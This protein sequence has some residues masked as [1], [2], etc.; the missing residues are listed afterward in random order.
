M[1]R[2]TTRQLPDAAERFK[3]EENLDT[4]YLVEAAAGTGKTTSMVR[5]MTALVA[6]GKT[7]VHRIAAV[8]FTRK[9]ASEL[10]IR[11]LLRLEEALAEAVNT[12]D[13]EKADRIRE[14]VENAGRCFVGTIHSFCARL[15]RERPVEAGVDPAFTEMDEDDDERLRRVSWEEQMSGLGSEEELGRILAAGL[16]PGELFGLF[17]T[18]T[19]QPDVDA[20]PAPEPV[21]PDL[22]AALGALTDYLA[23]IDA[24]LP[25]L[26]AETASDS[27]IPK[28]R[29]VRRMVRNARDLADPLTLFTILETFALSVKPVQRNFP[30]GKEQALGEAKRW[31]KFNTEVAAPAVTAFM[32]Y[33]YAV[34]LQT[35]LPAAQ[36]YRKLRTLTG[37]L[38]YGDLLLKAA[39]L[40]KDSPE[41]RR[42]F[43]D[44]YR[45]L[46][47]DE[48]Q[49]TDPVQAEV[50][51]FLTATDANERDWRRCVPGPGSLFVVGDPKQS[52]YRFRRADIAIYNE[53]RDI[54]TGAP[55]STSSGEKIELTANFRSRPEILSWVNEVFEPHFPT[56][57]TDEAPR[58][59]P[60]NP[61][62]PPVEGSSQSALAGIRT[63]TLPPTCT[64]SEK[65]A[66]VEPE[67][68]A[69][70]IRHMVDSGAT[71]TGKD[72]SPRPCT[73]GDF[74]IVTMKK[75]NLTPFSMALDRW[76]IPHQV[77]GGTA[78]GEAPELRDLYV[79]VRA[80]ARPH[81]PVAFVAALRSA[82]FGFSDAELLACRLAGSR[83]RWDDP[84]TKG[85]DKNLD[86]RLGRVKETFSL[87][88]RW[89]ATLPAVA[90]LERMA[91]ALGLPAKAALSADGDLRAGSLYKALEILRGA[92]AQRPTLDHILETL[93]R[94]LTG[95]EAHD[96]MGALPRP[97]SVVR[98]MNLHKVK[99]LEAPVVFLATPAGQW[100]TTPSLHIERSGSE[101]HGYAEVQGAGTAFGR[102]PTV[103]HPSRW[104]ED[105]APREEAFLEAELVR[106]RY[107]AATRA[108]SMLVITKAP[109][110]GSHPWGFF[111]KH[112]DGAS[113]LEDPVD[114]VPPVSEEEEIG[115]DEA[116]DPAAYRERWEELLKPGYGKVFP[117]RLAAPGKDPQPPTGEHG[118]AWGTVIHRLLEAA[119]GSDLEMK[120][121]EELAAV[122][123][124][125]EELSKE[126]APRAAATVRSVIASDTWKRAQAASQC[127]TEI[128]YTRTYIK[129]GM[130][131]I[132][133]GVMDLVFLEAGG[134]VIVDYK[135]GSKDSEKYRPQLEAYREAW[136]SFEVGEV[137]EVGIYWVDHNTYD[138]L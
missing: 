39:A 110:A 106:L 37:S 5:R 14:A 102:G 4:N 65:I 71:V 124:I 56:E 55:G 121:L 90:A 123:L 54:I 81:D 51:M 61:G 35:V 95:E 83:F 99:G 86:E 20:W 77:T 97:S 85:I 79:A 48:F 116:G 26:P 28:M 136:E 125:D 113:E 131:T 75:E 53:V 72:G 58:Y 32:E 44:R 119:M 21:L 98:V 87:F 40:L 128:P 138:P 29:R 8:T 24:L 42:F 126:E 69:R 112:L 60:L 11:F 57:E 127:F 12:G 105:W 38:N 47:V 114:I 130:D 19:G 7:P 89:L 120:E 68:T 66:Q 135:T 43:Q 134:W 45:Y 2:E 80:A 25:Q 101:V 46:L 31:E 34:A 92:A 9:A 16:S 94:L 104:L 13:E 50:M 129:E 27:L 30:G 82:M 63:V 133:T 33:R 41:V 64:S 10:K 1:S 109:R 49:D 84:V 18:V 73:W 91:E 122:Y 15:L 115:P 59:V 3:I 103:A 74:L 111:Y 6:S 100:S 78:L 22:T 23:H 137:K 88:V 93:E 118:T 67:R 108:G 96:G 132:E 117:S 36:R 70:T 62:R 76:S 107:V 17:E 52:I